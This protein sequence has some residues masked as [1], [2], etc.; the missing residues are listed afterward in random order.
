MSI[1]VKTAQHHSMSEKQNCSERNYLNNLL[2]KGLIGAHLCLLHH[3]HIGPNPG[4]E[5]KLRPLRQLVS[6]LKF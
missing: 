5:D 4:A 3:G 1:K 6:S 2:Y